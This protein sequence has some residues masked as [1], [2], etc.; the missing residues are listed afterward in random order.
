M[1]IFSVILVFSMVVAGIFLAKTY[2]CTNTHS[3]KQDE[4]H[5][6]QLAVEMD[7]LII[8]GDIDRAIEKYDKLVKIAPSNT[9]IVNAAP[10]IENARAEKKENERKS[11]IV[12]GLEDAEEIRLSSK[13][14]S[15][16]KSISEAWHKLKLSKPIDDNRTAVEKSVA[17]LEKC[18]KVC[19]KTVPNVLKQA[20]MKDR[21]NMVPTMTEVFYKKGLDVKFTA[22]GKYKDVLKVRYVLMNDPWVYQFTSHVQLMTN[23]TNAGFKKIILT[24]GYNDS[25]TYKL[26]PEDNSMLLYSTGMKALG[27]DSKLELH[28]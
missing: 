18:R 26:H 15:E 17:I 25:W 3:L 22:L 20:Q 7:K 19:D 9:S 16:P 8:D 13:L 28:E 2:G 11:T 27:I 14:C 4:I 10:V 23:L 12:S 6:K 1:R 5:A 24:D 21:E